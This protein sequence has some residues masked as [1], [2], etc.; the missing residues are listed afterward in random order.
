MKNKDL[1]PMQ[2]AISPFRTKPV[3]AV[4]DFGLR[5]NIQGPLQQTHLLISSKNNRT[6][7]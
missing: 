1:E 7:S 2:N 6:V 3:A 4:N 5:K